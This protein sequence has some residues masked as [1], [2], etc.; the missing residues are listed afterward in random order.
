M[1]TRR[2]TPG[3]HGASTRSAADPGR[4]STLPRASSRSSS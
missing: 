1:S 4:G 2:S 3:R